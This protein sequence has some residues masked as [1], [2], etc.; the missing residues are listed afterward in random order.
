MKKSTLHWEVGV[1]S[2]SLNNDLDQL[3]QLKR[4]TGISTVHLHIRPELGRQMTT[5][6]DGLLHH[7]WRISAGMVT[8]DQEDYSTPATIRKTGGIVPD[9]YWPENQRKIQ[10]ALDILSDLRV[11]YLTFHFGVLD[12]ENDLLCRKIKSL[13]DCAESKGIALLMETGQENAEALCGFLQTLNHPALGIN[14]DPANMILYDSGQPAEALKLLKKRIRHIHIKDA[15]PPQQAG[16]WGSEVPWG[17][18]RVNPEGFFRRLTEIRYTGA[19]CIE[20]E[21]GTNKYADIISA[22]K[23]IHSFLK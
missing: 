20:R 9:Q 18:G 14:F 23:N 4:E 16:F 1:C 11:P 22:I 12:A 6:A 17:D 15:L 3:M 10:K 19:L 7:G 21:Q 2:W 5:L 8:F 13:A